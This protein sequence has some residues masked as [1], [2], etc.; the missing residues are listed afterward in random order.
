LLKKIVIVAGVMAALSPLA[1]AQEWV[2]PVRGSWV[3]AG[4]AQTGDVT[5]A[6]PSAVAEI[7]I[8]PG[9]HTAVQHAAK[10]LA[11][12]IGK[13]SGE[14]PAIVGAP[15]AAQV[16]I[17]LVTLGKGR[18]PSGVASNRLKGQWEAYQIYTEP[19]DVWLVGSDFR[20]TAFA[21]FTLS[22]RLGIDPLYQWTGYTPEHR[23]PL[24]LKKTNAYTAS[25]TFKYRGMFHDDEDILPRGFDPRNGYPY[26]RGTVPDEWYERFFETALRL[27]MN[28]VAP[29]TRVKRPFHVNKMASDWGLFYTSHHY[30]ILLS[31][32][33]G[34]DNFD[35]AKERGVTGKYDY[36]TNRDGIEKFWRGGVEENK[37]LDAIYPVGI[38]GTDDT[39]YVFPKGTTLEQKGKVFEDAIRDQIKMTKDILPADKQPGLFTLT[40]YNEMLDNY[41]SGTFNLPEDV[42]LIWDDDG[43]GNMRG[44]PDQL[45]KWKHGVYYHLAFFGITAKQSVHTVTPMRVVDQFQNI[46]KS[47]ATEYMLVNVSELREF[48]MET[49]LLAEI[50]WDAKTAL[51]G[52]DPA[53]RY[54]NWW[55]REY[56]GTEAAPLA[57]QSYAEYYKIIDEQHKIWY[58][59]VRT[60][61]ALEQLMLKTNGQEFK[62][63]EPA[64][65]ATLKSRLALYEKAWPILDA[66]QEKM[67]PEQAEFFHE[68][69]RLGLSFDYYPTQSALLL[70]QALETPDNAKSMDLVRQS[71]PPLETLEADIHRA[72]RHPFE[73]WYRPTW[74]RVADYYNGWSDMNPHRPY[75]MV[76]MFLHGRERGGLAPE[77]RRTA[78]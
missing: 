50:C 43:D 15:G 7:V 37:N 60:K 23:N 16:R 73:E 69:V 36:F 61:W 42:M 34:Y 28:M 63:L 49:R 46:V 77:S 52:P 27:R 12:D 26:I 41:K 54:I 56:F 25:P 10:L 39:P 71:L 21:A 57:A 44:L 76:T 68:H 4:A 33:Y 72:E 31:N 48:I 29:Y 70:E 8:S 6:S 64:D 51:A 32:P 5:L 9:E 74:I 35:L 40:L 19:R 11:G 18:L 13:I 30:D 3:R 17:H 65:V 47:G 75:D 45:G 78:P 67:G 53:Q 14:T 66:A 55:S 38:R 2:G 24:V 1:R 59:S 62:K 22:E 58:G 20:G